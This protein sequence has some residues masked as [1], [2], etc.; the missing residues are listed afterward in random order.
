M[1]K[2]I[3]CNSKTFLVKNV[4]LKYTILK[5][6]ICK[7]EF[8]NP[9]PSKKDLDSFYSNYSDLRASDNNVL[10]KNSKRI[11]NKIKLKYGLTKSS[12]L[13]DFGSGKNS[14]LTGNLPNNFKSYDPYTFNNDKNLLTK[15]TYDYITFLG[16]LE[17]LTEIKKTICH[18]MSLLKKNGILIITTVDINQVIPFRYK[19]P[20]HTIYFTH[21]AII[22]LF[23]GFKILEYS[24]YF[25]V[26]N[27]DIYLEILHRSMP[28]KYKK[29]IYNNLPQ[30][31]EIPTNEVFIVI[32]K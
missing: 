11:Y 19:P 14:F 27:S 4:D 31:V 6:D 2:C 3:I 15:N 20:E 12:N 21:A 17:H 22:E 26:Q 30:I 23:K 7:V 8:V 1:I 29:L 25:M 10:E 28:N 9:M 16:V 5:C 32:K 13:L 18:L 24:P